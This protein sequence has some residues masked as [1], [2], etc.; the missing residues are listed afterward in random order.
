MCQEGAAFTD[1]ISAADAHSSFEQ[2]YRQ[3]RH[4]FG[5]F[6]NS[7]SIFEAFFYGMF[8]VGAILEPYKFP[9]TSQKDQQR[10]SPDSTITQYKAAFA[11]DP[12][13]SVMEDVIGTGAYGDIKIVRN[14]LTH[15]TA[16]GRVIYAGL[17]DVGETAPPT[18][19]IQNVIKPI[20]ID[21]G[22][23]ADRRADTAKLLASLL[24]AS[25]IFIEARV[26]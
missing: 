11:G 12:L 13:I 2:R 3:E 9:I 4:L 5:L 8:A 21:L 23:A 6:S 16:P 20:D 15:R 17:D 24:D 19:K 22:T 14:V 10:V 25:A 18:W 1:S 7:V 26:G